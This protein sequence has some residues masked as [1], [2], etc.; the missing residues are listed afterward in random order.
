M[1]SHHF[2]AFARR[3]ASA[4]RRQAL[5]TLL[6]TGVFRGGTSLHEVAAVCK[7]YNGKCKKNGSCCGVDGLRCK[8]GRCRCQGGWQRCLPDAASCQNLQADVNHCGACGNQCSGATPCCINGVCQPLCGDTCCLDC[9]IEILGGGIPNP[10][11]QVCC[12]GPEGTIC[13]PD[14]IKRKKGKKPKPTDPAADLCCYPDE[15]CVNGECCCDGCQ[16]MVI[17]GDTCCAQDA[18]CNGECCPAGQVCATTASGQVCVQAGRSC[19][20]G[21]LLNEVC[22]G[23]V[24]CSGLR[25][26]DDVCCSEGRYCAFGYCCPV[27]SICNT[28]RGRRVRR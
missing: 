26:C 4:T 24:C 16:G 15:T 5:A 23:G 1:D 28:Y 8:N 9:F 7:G 13:S 11:N 25:V 10:S 20:E 19:A 2:D 17:C 12:P 3:F 27:K 6:A 21:C 14:P 22:I 18:C